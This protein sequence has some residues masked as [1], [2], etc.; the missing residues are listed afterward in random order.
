[1]RCSRSDERARRA[2]ACLAVAVAVI[3]V[4]GCG[5]GSERSASRPDNSKETTTT[6]TKDSGTA[7]DYVGLTK[8]AAIEKAEADGRPWRIGREDDER[9]LLTLDYNPNRVTFEIDDGKVT[10]ATFG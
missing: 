5:G 1:V 6:T 9:F 3:A 8:Q 4:A 2:L 10:T 7:D